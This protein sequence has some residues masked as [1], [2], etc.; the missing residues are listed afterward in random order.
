MRERQFGILRIFANRFAVLSLVCV[1]A[2]ALSMG[3]A[4]SSLLERA[5]S[6]WEWENT[7]AF[8]QHEVDLFNLDSLFEAPAGPETAQRW[9]REVSRLFEGL[10][11]VVRIKVWNRQA[12]VLWSDEER[13]IGRHFPDNRNLAT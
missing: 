6:Q 11:E 3:F 2:L 13:L 9:R 12:T 7:A 4:L 1:A 10:P 5:V 8:A